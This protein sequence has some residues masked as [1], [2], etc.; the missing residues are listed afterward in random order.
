MWI[1]ETRAAINVFRPEL[2]I[3]AVRDSGTVDTVSDLRYAWQPTAHRLQTASNR[4]YLPFRNGYFEIP[5]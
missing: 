2:G 4:F 1:T 5:D 3:P